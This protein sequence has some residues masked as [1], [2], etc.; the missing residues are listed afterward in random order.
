MPNKKNIIEILPV[1]E[2]Q[3]KSVFQFLLSVKP[4]FT[5]PINLS[6]L[7]HKNSTSFV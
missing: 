6:F 3:L 1:R 2:G 7:V 5:G 4:D